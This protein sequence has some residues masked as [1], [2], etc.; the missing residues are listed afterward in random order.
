[1]AVALYNAR[2]FG[3]KEQ[4]DGTWLYR[5]RLWHPI[6]YLTNFK[7]GRYRL[8]AEDGRAANEFARNKIWSSKVSDLIVFIGLL[9]TLTLS[10]YFSNYQPQPLLA[11]LIIGWLIQ[12]Y[13]SIQLAELCK[14]VG[15]L[16]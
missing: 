13:T 6:A 10:I 11:G 14:K 7:S 1:M 4:E 9:A 5:P 16:C 3:L 2:I 8:S 12:N 15:T